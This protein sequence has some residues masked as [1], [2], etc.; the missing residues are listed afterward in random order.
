MGNKTIL[1]ILIMYAMLVAGCAGSDDDLTL[2]PPRPDAEAEVLFTTD[3]D[4]FTR[5]TTGSIDNL[6]A[7]K[8]VPEG[9]G[10]FA[11][12]T[13]EK[14]WETATGGKVGSGSDY[15]VPD[16]MMNQ[17]VQ[18]LVQTIDDKGEGIKDWVYSP[19]KYWPNGTQGTDDPGN[20]SDNLDAANQRHIS[21]FAYAPHVERPQPS[22][23]TNF[24]RAEDKSPH[25]W[26]TMG[27]G[28]NQV[29]LLWANCID[30]RRNEKGLIEVDKS[31]KAWTYQRV[32]LTF[33]HALASVDIYVQRVY[34]E[35]AFT[36]NTPEIA[37]GDEKITYT[38]L[39]VSELQLEATG[40]DATPIFGSKGRLNLVDGTWSQVEGRLGD[41]VKDKLLTFSE[42]IIEEKMRGT[43]RAEFIEEE[44]DK[45]AREGY[46]V[47]GEERRLFRAD[48]LIMLIPQTLTI[49]PKV[50]YSMLTR[51]DA[52]ESNADYQVTETIN[53]E[54]VTHYYSR[55]VNTL[56][57]NPVTITFESGK[58]YILLLRIGVEHI[59][60]EVLSVAD[61]DFP[62]RF[63]PKVD[64]NFTEDI[65]GHRLDEPL[66]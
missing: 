14:S 66:D 53:G 3:M 50:T 20:P 30:A 29:D 49:V 12:L 46:G 62:L 59:S 24:V 65:I 35:Q 41:N 19:L 33:K 34:D 38:K 18:W 44:L 17:P 7:L 45:W 10:V 8:A 58:K 16:F 51:D 25:V 2:V 52:L 11:Y 40:P 64:A 57:A 22:G 47:D 28:G 6:D 42:S 27:E 21:F 56:K 63:D 54:D 39:F 36:G 23:I 55:I 31:Q 9:F 15:P 5:T 1:Y 32:P 48:S 61:W 60:L 43:K 13:D 26:Y 4:L 37:S